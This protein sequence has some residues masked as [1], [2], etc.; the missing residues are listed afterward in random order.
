[1]AEHKVL[2][3]VSKVTVERGAPGA[4]T[5]LLGI[6]ETVQEITPEQA[7][8]IAADLI[9]HADALHSERPASLTEALDQYDRDTETIRRR[10][11]EHQANPDQEQR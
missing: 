4:G 10:T 5:L 9:A 6:E 1:M 3:G 2:Y 7:R 11:Q 8:A